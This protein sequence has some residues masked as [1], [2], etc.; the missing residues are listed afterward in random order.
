MKKHYRLLEQMLSERIL[1]FAMSNLHCHACFV[2]HDDLRWQASVATAPTMSVTRA[3][4]VPVARGG[5]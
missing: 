3:I 4:A 1:F 2:A 5:R